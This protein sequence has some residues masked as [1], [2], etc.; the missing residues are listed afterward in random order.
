MIK[1]NLFIIFLCLCHWANA[2]RQLSEEG[3]TLLLNLSDVEKITQDYFIPLLVPRVS[4]SEGNL[5]VQNVIINHFQMLGWNIEED[6][7]TDS[8][9]IGDVS[10]NNIIVTKNINATN[11]IVLA[12]HYDTKYFEPPNDGFLGAVDSAVSC[13]ILINLAHKL[14]PYFDNR[15]DPDSISTTLQ[16]IFFDGQEAFKDW[17]STDA[18]YGSRYEIK[19]NAL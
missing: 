16:I 17:T 1:L 12:A 10:F 14:D 15:G 8:T 2:Y 5:K 9:P 19:I 7:F 3:L 4:G 13:A 11:R 6:K 18:L